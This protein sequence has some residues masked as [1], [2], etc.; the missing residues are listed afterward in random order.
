MGGTHHV[1]AIKA[2]VALIHRKA[3]ELVRRSPVSPSRRAELLCSV[4]PIRER[5]VHR[6]L[7]RLYPDL[8]ERIFAHRFPLTLEPLFGAG[9][10]LIAPRRPSRIHPS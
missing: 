7:A 2:Q 1:D 10:P 8:F 3:D 6:E 4:L 5:E 9:L